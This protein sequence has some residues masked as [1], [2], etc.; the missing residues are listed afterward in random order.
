MECIARLTAEIAPEIFSE[1]CMMGYT[2]LG[3]VLFFRPDY[4]DCI[5]NLTAMLVPQMFGLSQPP[6][7]KTFLQISLD[8]N[9]NE[10]VDCILQMTIERAPEIFSRRCM[11]NHTPLEY[12]LSVQSKYVECIVEATAKVAPEILARSCMMGYTPL[13]YTLF[14]QPE[15]LECI[16]TATAKVAPEV[17]KNQ[18]TFQR[19]PLQI[20]LDFKNR[21]NFLYIAQLTSEIA[22]EAFILKIYCGR[23]LIEYALSFFSKDLE[24]IQ[25]ILNYMLKADPSFLLRERFNGNSLLADSLI[26]YPEHSIY[27]AKLVA[28]WASELFESPDIYG[29]IPLSRAIEL[30]N[31]EIFRCILDLSVKINPMLLTCVDR[32]G[33]SVLARAVF[34]RNVEIAQDIAKLTA[35]YAPIVYCD[36]NK[37]SQ[38]LL[39]RALLNKIPEIFE[40]LVLYISEYAPEKF[41]STDRGMDSF[42]VGN[43]FEFSCRFD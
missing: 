23:T 32:F 43:I 33:Y 18:D 40:S 12:V 30:K 36:K 7:N 29:L 5:A 14:C 8:S 37:I 9:S 1:S 39:S 10:N 4:V 17:F 41:S 13:G 25:M 42:R 16:A 2:P 3:Y 22:P 26:L 28:K 24:L 15:Y 19:A 38:S 35:R 31:I 6:H 34:S 27:I 11:M 21:E 20:A